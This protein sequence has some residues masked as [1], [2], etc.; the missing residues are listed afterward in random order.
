MK[1]LLLILCAVSLYTI[2]NAEVYNSHIGISGSVAP[3]ND[4]SYLVT[5]FNSNG[6]EDRHYPTYTFEW[7]LS[8]KGKRVSDY[9]T[10]AVVARS[11]GQQTARCWPGEVPRGHESYVTVQFG[12]EKAPKDRRDDF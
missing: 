4:G 11:S 7:Y 10:A 8:Y 3:Q 2:A 5:F 9:Y 12:R 6:M 1:K